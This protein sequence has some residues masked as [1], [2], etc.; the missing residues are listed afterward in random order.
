MKMSKHVPEDFDSMSLLA[1][2]L[3]ADFSAFPIDILREDWSCTIDWGRPMSESHRLALEKE[4]FEIIQERD[5][6]YTISYT[7][8]T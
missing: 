3:Y 6:I 4:G 7:Y 1:Q 5:S 8:E 2:K